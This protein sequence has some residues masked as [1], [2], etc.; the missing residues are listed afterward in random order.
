[1]NSHMDSAE[2]KLSVGT[3]S[4]IQRVREAI[5]PQILIEKYQ[6]VAIPIEIC[7]A[8]L[9]Y[10]EANYSKSKKTHKVEVKIDQDSRVA[11]ILPKVYK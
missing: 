1:M 6:Q 7:K 11:K 10:K 3:K 2:L 5:L 4:K 9:I 8:I